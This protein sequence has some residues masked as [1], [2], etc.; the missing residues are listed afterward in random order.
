MPL[1]PCPEPE[2]ENRVSTYADSCP[3]CG[4]RITNERS[5]E[6]PRKKKALRKTKKKSA[7]KTKKGIAPPPSNDD[8]V[9]I[10]RQALLDS[11]FED[12]EDSAYL[13]NETGNAVVHMFSSSCVDVLAQNSCFWIEEFQG[14]EDGI[15]ESVLVQLSRF[16]HLSK[17]NLF[18]MRERDFDDSFIYSITQIKS[19]LF[20]FL[21]DAAYEAT[22]GGMMQLATM[23]QL[24]FLAVPSIVGD[25]HSNSLRVGEKVKSKLRKSL[26]NASV[27]NTTDCDLS[28]FESLK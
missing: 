24:R 25:D 6:S 14:V 16:P 1:I 19:L 15:S 9:F 2:C 21:P 17:L 28:F 10:E 18:M 13:L 8:P 22:E 11:I 5:R 23:Q 27:V 26:L 12:R 3:I 7:K 20:L 4:C